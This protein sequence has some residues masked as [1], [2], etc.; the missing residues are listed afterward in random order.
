MNGG[1]NILFDAPLSTD[2]VVRK[3]A[4]PPHRLLPV[5][6]Q[7]RRKGYDT[8]KEYLGGTWRSCAFQDFHM[9][10]IR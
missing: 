8:C 10:E 7:M 1:V 4:D 3:M 2:S 5:N 9:E 6:L